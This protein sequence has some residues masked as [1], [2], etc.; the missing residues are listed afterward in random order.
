MGDLIH[1]QCAFWFTYVLLAKRSSAGY[2]TCVILFSRNAN[3]LCS[4]ILLLMRIYYFVTVV[5]NRC[6]HKTVYISFM[7]SAIIT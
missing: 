2:A 5:I 1:S 6:Y 7:S 3:S 4:L